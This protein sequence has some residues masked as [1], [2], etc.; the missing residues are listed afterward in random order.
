MNVFSVTQ[1]TQIKT[2]GR[3]YIRKEFVWHLRIVI[4]ETEIQVELNE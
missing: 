4:W 3:L 1:C 2:C